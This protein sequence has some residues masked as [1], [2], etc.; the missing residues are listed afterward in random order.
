MG[1]EGDR[2]MEFW[3]NVFMEFNRDASGHLEPL[4]MQSVDTG[5]GMERITTILQGKTTVYDTDLFTPLLA[6]IE[7]ASGRRW[8][9]RASN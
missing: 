2:Y 5:M 4:S 6:A 8:V 1:G 7:E 9:D 3:N